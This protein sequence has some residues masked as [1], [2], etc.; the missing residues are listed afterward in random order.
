[1][2]LDLQFTRLPH[3]EGLPVPSRQ[4]EGA[5]GYDIVAAQ[6][7]RSSEL[8][9]AGS[10]LAEEVTEEDIAEVVGRWTGIPVSKLMEGEVAKLI[11]SFAHP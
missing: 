11:L 6:E 10:L 1:M 7:R 4:T 9:E 2:T 3:A 8:D 5:A